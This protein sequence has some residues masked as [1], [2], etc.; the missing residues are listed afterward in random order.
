MFRNTM[1]NICGVQVH[2]LYIRLK[3]F[4]LILSHIQLSVIVNLGQNNYCWLYYYGK[5]KI[6]SN[7]CKL[8]IIY[9]VFSGF[10]I[11]H[12]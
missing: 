1:E 6:I 9:Y 10:D 8:I 12:L 11:L 7:S 4:L 2:E 5:R 3:Y